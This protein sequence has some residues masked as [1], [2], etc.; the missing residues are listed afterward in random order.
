MVSL[1]VAG[2]TKEAIPKQSPAISESWRQ[3]KGTT[4]PRAAFH[5]AISSSTEGKVASGGWEERTGFS[6]G[7]AITARG[8]VGREAAR[9]PK[10]RRG[11]INRVPKLS[12]Q[13]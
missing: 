11:F 8:T 2:N 10:L 5:A 4:G 9:R 7:A 13:R 1:T 12:V 6:T 3:G